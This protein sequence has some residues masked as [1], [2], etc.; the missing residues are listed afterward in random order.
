MRGAGPGEEGGPRP[1]GGR[2]GDRI[3]VRDLRVLGVHGVLPEER[4]R[5]QP[6]ALDLSVWLD[7]RPAGA[8]DALEDTVDYAALAA[9]AAGTVADRSFRLLEALADAVAQAVL[10]HDDRVA[11]A[12]VTVRKLRPPLPF[13]VGSVGVRVVRRRDVG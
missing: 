11:A 4:E 7:V 9:L 5:P 6:F 2:W 1:P 12:A 10:G 8:S 13:D 3:E